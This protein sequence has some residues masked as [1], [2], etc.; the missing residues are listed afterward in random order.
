MV[1]FKLQVLFL[2]MTHNKMAQ[3]ASIVSSKHTKK[4]KQDSD[5]HQK[6]HRILKTNV[7]ITQKQ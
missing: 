2:T 3:K 1:L 5:I 4:K 7:I 6:S